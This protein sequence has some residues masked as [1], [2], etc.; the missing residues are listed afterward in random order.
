MEIVSKYLKS[1][2][3]TISPFLCASVFKKITLFCCFANFALAQASIKGGFLN[4]LST[5]SGQG[6]F[7]N[8]HKFV[9]HYFVE[10][11]D[12]S[13]IPSTVKATIYRIRD[14]QRVADITLQQA[15]STFNRPNVLRD[16]CNV[17]T[18]IQTVTLVADYRFEPSLFND[19]AGY[20]VVTE[21][22]CCR[23]N[24]D[25]LAQSNTPVVHYM[26]IGPIN[27]VPN[28]P[29]NPHTPQI[30]IFSLLEYCLDQEVLL[31]PRRNNS[32]LFT[33]RY[34]MADPL[35]SAAD[36][37]FG[38]AGL[39]NNFSSQN[40]TGN[41][42]S[43]QID[44]TTGFIS[45]KTEKPGKYSFVMRMEAYIKGEKY[46][47]VR[48][49]F[50]FI[51]NNCKRQNTPA[52]LISAVNNSQLPLKNK[53]C[54]DSLV[55]LNLVSHTAGG[56]F[57]WQS[58]GVNLAGAADSVLR[59]PRN[60]S[61]VYTCIV[62][63]PKTCPIEVSANVEINF[64]DKPLVEISSVLP[65]GTPCQ[66][67]SIKLTANTLTPNV[68]FEWLRNGQPVP[69]ASRQLYETTQ[70]GSYVVRITDQNGCKGESL[71]QIITSNNPPKAE[72]IAS[73]KVICEGQNLSLSA[74]NA[75][76]GQLYQ[77]LRNGT[78]VANATQ[79]TH[80]TTT[81]GNYTLK[82]TDDKGCSATSPVFTVRQA[83]TPK[84]EITP[85]NNQT[86]FCENTILRAN[87]PLAAYQWLRNGTPVASATNNIFTVNEGG[88]YTL[89]ATD[90]N[91][92][93]GVSAVVLLQKV[94]K[95][96]VTLDSVLPFCGPNQSALTLR[97]SPVGGV[98]EG[99]GVQ[100]NQFVPTVAGVGSFVVSY[101]VG[102]TGTC[103]SGKA[104]RTVVVLPI[105]K[106][107]LGPDREILYGGKILLNGDLGKAYTY[108]WTPPTGLDSSLTARPIASPQETTT[109]QLT[110]TAND[111]CTAT[112]SI[113]ITVRQGVFIPN[114]FSPNNDG[115]N[116]TWEI[117][118]LEAYPEAEVW[119]F[120]RWGQVVY[121]GQGGNRKPF[122]GSYNGMMLSVGSY[123]Y[124]IRP[125]PN[126]TAY[127][128]AVLLLR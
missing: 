103:A 13:K 22:V 93:V 46:S 121:Y 61:A 115:Q 82:I 34:A 110:A 86:T 41:V 7:H 27:R 117:K 65:T 33:F 44:P 92:C 30:Q 54:Q 16:P 28:N 100:N 9:A 126:G 29:I 71:P 97:G 111:N 108:R 52:I 48:Q 124:K 5:G 125:Q 67:E 94:T 12:I 109:Y 106:L 3:E 99:V 89:Q 6:G 31:R 101:S 120:D 127:H 49:E 98:Y 104:T 18:T 69:N 118:G 122:D 90:T 38:V 8:D 95:I 83:T 43:L 20:Y 84:V 51:V 37:P 68:T 57:Q 58:E 15:G 77:W 17:A 116:D 10:N 107:N 45:G 36:K 2:A 62:S 102:T 64:L 128:G 23:Q 55:Q 63:N 113:K 96:A 19:L 47:E 119:V 79:A 75:S 14:N 74:S 35:T 88:S 50:Q 73:K 11:P 42:N 21:P 105:P 123:T 24:T 59:V 112:D 87:A 60:R 80:N 76:I 39:K 81:A 40:F 91:G 4:D 26:E 32:D 85:Q 78:P 1:L 25:N 53:V 114:V 56:T 70:S 66:T 72:I